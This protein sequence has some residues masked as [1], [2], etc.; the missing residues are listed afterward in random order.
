MTGYLLTPSSHWMSLP[1]VGLLPEHVHVALSTQDAVGWREGNSDP[2]HSMT[3]ETAERTQ[4]G[5][6][7][8]ARPPLS[9]NLDDQKCQDAQATGALTGQRPTTDNF[10]GTVITTELRT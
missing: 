9:N 1:G 10:T 3:Q 4:P 6:G 7:S 8:R 5:K 2:A